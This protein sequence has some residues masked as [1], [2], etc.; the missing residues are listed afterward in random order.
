MSNVFIYTTPH[1][2]HKAL[3]DSLNCKGIQ[4]HRTGIAKTPMIG[5]LLATS[6]VYK[7][8]KKHNPKIILTESVSTDL[9]AGAY[10]KSKNP[11]V[12]LIGLVTDPK[13]KEMKGA[14]LIDNAITM[15]ALDKADLLFVGSQMM[16]DMMPPSFKYKTKIFYPGIEKI[17]LYLKKKA[18]HG[19]NFVFIGRLD[20]HK[21]TDTLPRLFNCFKIKSPDSKLFIAGDGPNI[22]LFKNKIAKNIYYLGKTKNSLFMSDV[23][24][25]YI[26]PARFEPSGMAIAEAMA[27]GLVPIVTEGVGYKEFVKRV[28][29]RLVVTRDD[30]AV[31]IAMKLIKNKPLW[32]ELSLKCKAQVK[33][34]TYKNSVKGFKTILKENNII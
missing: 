31:D 17:E 8:I 29:H 7:E 21:G 6:G 2:A 18:K 13:I 26:S 28:D 24:S 25:M 27:Q 4:T 16:F 32:T 12:K 30:D 5:R 23:A 20:D 22:D 34:L 19:K 11:T 1:S 10:Y 33:H 14:P 9:L 15:W 3:A